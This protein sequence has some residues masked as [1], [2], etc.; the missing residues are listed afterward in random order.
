M[1]RRRYYLFTPIV[2]VLAGAL[3]LTLESPAPKTDRPALTFTIGDEQVT[4]PVEPAVLRRRT[5]TPEFDPPLDVVAGRIV[6]ARGFVAC[7]PGEV[8]TVNVEVTQDGASGTGRTAGVCT[9][10]TQVWTAIVVE[11]SGG[12]FVAGPAE[13]CAV[14]TTRRLGITD[15]FEWCGTPELTPTD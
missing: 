11:R 3:V 14:A 6:F 5:I 12:E 7:D 9:G 8:F 13:A 4:A 1:Q 15:T 2:L 10:E